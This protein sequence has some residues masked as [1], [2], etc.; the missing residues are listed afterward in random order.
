MPTI[1][2]NDARGNPVAPSALGWTSQSTGVAT[3]STATGVITAVSEG[4]SRVIATSGTLADT[5]LI[6]VDQIPA[7]ITISPANFGTPDVTMRTNQT[8]P[9]Y[10]TVLDSLGH[11]ASHDSVTWSTDNAAVADVSGAATLDSTV[12]STFASAGTATITAMAGPA[13]VSRVVNVSTTALS[14]ATDVQ[15]VF[16]NNC[17]ACHGG[18]NPPEGMS[19]VAGVS[20]PNIVDHP[21]GEVA[22]LTRVRP[23]RPDSSYLIHKIQ[24]T[25]ATV[26]GSGARMPFGCS[27]AGCLPDATINTIRNWILQG[28]P[29]N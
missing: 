15:T 4:Q 8:A 23:F 12:I 26:G 13:T 6:T 17:T 16:T 25:Q 24:G 5:V 10:A 1:T 3:V 20:Y 27:G 21:A 9:F 7:T 19:L 2:A 14:Y 18:S 29:N 28:A 11:V 22:A